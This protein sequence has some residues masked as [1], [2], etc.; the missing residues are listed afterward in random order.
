MQIVLVMFRDNGQRRSFSLTRDVT[1]IGRREDCDFRI[2]LGEVSRK[3]CRLLRDG[4]RVRVEDL[5]SS[6]GTFVNGRRVQ[7]AELHA[8]DTLQVGPLAF[9]LQ[10]DGQPDEEH[11][12]PVRVGAAPAAATP[13]SGDSSLDPATLLMSDPD[14]SN[15][16]LAVTDDAIEID[17]E[18]SEKQGR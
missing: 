4:Q 6:N 13:S 2:P 15:A 10:L 12:S 9:V 17:F 8:G 16:G 11:M 1:V 5:G 3:H 18:D 14:D 7:E